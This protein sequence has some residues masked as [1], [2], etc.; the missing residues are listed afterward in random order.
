MVMTRGRVLQ[1][2]GAALEK[3][4]SHKL[5]SYDLGMTRCPAVVECSDRGEEG[6]RGKGDKLVK[7]RIL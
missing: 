4:L 3:P 7:R 1:R 6:L 5:W 2:L